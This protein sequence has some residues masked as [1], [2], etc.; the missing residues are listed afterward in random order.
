MHLHNGITV[1]ASYDHRSNA[2]TLD[3]NPGLETIALR[4][5]FPF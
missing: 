5:A 2:D 4:V 1:L 3:V